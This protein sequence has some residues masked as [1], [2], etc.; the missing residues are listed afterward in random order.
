MTTTA[1]THTTEEKSGCISF[2]KQAQKQT[3]RVVLTY[4]SHLIKVQ[5]QVVLSVQDC[6]LPLPAQA[7]S[8]F[9]HIFCLENGM[10][11]DIHCRSTTSLRYQPTRFRW[12]NSK[13]LLGHNIK[14]FASQ[15]IVASSHYLLTKLMH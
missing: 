9:H 12:Q 1:T 4:T 15:G 5:D 8:R 10:P 6:C 14:F 2:Q 13:R 11:I 3:A 7:S